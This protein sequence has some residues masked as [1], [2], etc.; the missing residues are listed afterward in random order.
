MVWRYNLEYIVF[1]Y[2][3]FEVMYDIV[4]CCIVNIGGYF[5]IR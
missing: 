5:Y 2:V 3:L 4:K 1:D